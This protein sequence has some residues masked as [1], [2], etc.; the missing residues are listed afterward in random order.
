MFP[1]WWTSIELANSMDFNNSPFS[2]LY[3]YIHAEQTL[4]FYKPATLQKL[5]KEARKD[6][7]TRASQEEKKD[8]KKKQE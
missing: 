2:A 7:K 3:L 8:R 5:Q 1:P 6:R 4:K